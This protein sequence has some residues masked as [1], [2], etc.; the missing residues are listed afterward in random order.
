MTFS[1]LCEAGWEGYFCEEMIDYCLNVT[2]ENR[3]ICCK[4]LRNYSCQCLRD[5][6]F[7][8]RCETKSN[9][10]L[11]ISSAILSLTK[12]VSSNSLELNLFILDCSAPIIELSPSSSLGMPLIFRPNQDIFIS[13]DI[14]INCS[15]SLS[16][17]RKW[18]IR[19]WSL[20][21][22]DPTD[23]YPSIDTTRNDLFIPART[24]ANGIYELNFT[25]FMTNIPEVF[26]SAFVYIEIMHSTL[27]THLIESDRSMIIHDIHEDLLL[28][29]GQFSLDRTRIAFDTDVN[30][31][32]K[33]TFHR[34]IYTLIF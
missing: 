24:L 3:G 20:I 18:T 12:I 6:Y 7:G 14:K 1:C 9:T 5:R 10:S 17:R 8:R 29:P 15:Q 19:N 31:W 28:D 26:S 2:C 11:T 25:V 32:S 23:F 27:M 22:S 34:D 4:V 13:S 30:H 33:E 16:I 21:C